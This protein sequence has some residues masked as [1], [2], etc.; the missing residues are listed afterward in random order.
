VSLIGEGILGSSRSV[1][2]QR[3]A[4]FRRFEALTTSCQPNL[5][6]RSWFT[7]ALGR[8]PL[9]PPSSVLEPVV[10]PVLTVSMK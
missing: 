10:T 5:A 3:I 8:S 1:V 6:R 7:G 4:S 9:M 2:R